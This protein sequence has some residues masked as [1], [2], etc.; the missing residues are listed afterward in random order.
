MPHACRAHENGALR[1]GKVGQ[2]KWRQKRTPSRLLSAWRS[3]HR[4]CAL[5]TILPVDCISQWPLTW[6]APAAAR[7]LACRVLS[8]LAW[9]EARVTA[10]SMARKA[11]GLQPPQHACLVCACKVTKVTEP[12]A[13]TPSAG[14]HVAPNPVS[15]RLHARSQSDVCS[16]S[17][18]RVVMTM[19]SMCEMQSAAYVLVH[20]ARPSPKRASFAQ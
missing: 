8:D 18:G 19:P 1:A 5:S 4:C 13:V 15:V 12:M 16:K 17:A 14:R 3:R 10:A 9:I 20:G 6:G 11:A 7:L 2:A